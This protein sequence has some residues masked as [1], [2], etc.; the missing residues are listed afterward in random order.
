MKFDIDKY[1]ERVQKGDMN[2][3]G[4]IHEYIFPRLRY[5]AVQLIN[6]E[7]NAE[8]IVQ[9]AFLRLWENRLYIFSK[10]QSLKTYMYHMVHNDCINRLVQKRTKKQSFIALSSSEYWCKIAESYAFDDFIVEK[11]EAQELQDK[12]IKI[13]DDLPD[14]CKEIFR[15]SRFEEKTNKEIALQLKIS[16][17]TVKTQIYRAL[18]K[19][20]KCIQY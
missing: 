5:Y 9:D 15:L 7:F 20:K 14:Q 19:I 2:A 6:D 13:V 10:K 12:I 17:S 18:E 11:L 3:F 1:W 4:V 16:T 8:E